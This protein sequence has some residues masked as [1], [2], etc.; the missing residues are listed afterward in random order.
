MRRF[1]P[2]RERIEH[3]VDACPEA[4]SGQRGHNTTFKLAIAL[5]HGFDLS[6]A[7]A[8]PF[9]QRYNQRCQPK[10]TIKELKHKLKDADDEIGPR[11]GR[12]LKVRGYLL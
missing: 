4:I 2:L 6:P 11:S 3:Y 7:A 8:L 1:F 5:V 10:W 12:P 9:L